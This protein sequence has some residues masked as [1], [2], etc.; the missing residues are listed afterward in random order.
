V[1]VLFVFN[2]Q[3]ISCRAQALFL[4][5]VSALAFIVLQSHSSKAGLRLLQQYMMQLVNTESLCDTF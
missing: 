5:Y 4:F 1:V 2:V 3:V